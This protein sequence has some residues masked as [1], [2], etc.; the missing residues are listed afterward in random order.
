MFTVSTCN[1]LEDP[2]KN[3]IVGQN[4][5]GVFRDVD[6]GQVATYANGIGETIQ[7]NLKTVDENPG[8]P[9]PTEGVS[10]F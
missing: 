6:L 3:L 9:L 1:C 2:I 4:Q 7:E 5:V 10:I 8:C